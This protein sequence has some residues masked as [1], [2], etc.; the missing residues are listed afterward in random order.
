[1]NNKPTHII[2]ISML[3]FVILNIIENIIHYN[4]GRYSSTDFNLKNYFKI[5]ELHEM[6]KIIGIMIVFAFLQGLFTE[7]ISDNIT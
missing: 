4:A 1:M 5:P 3:V 7:L 6:F 2:I